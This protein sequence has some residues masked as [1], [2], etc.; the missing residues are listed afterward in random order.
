MAMGDFQTIT[1]IYPRYKWYEAN[2][3][4]EPLGI[5]TLVAMLKQN[6][7]DVRFHDLTFR[8]DLSCLD[9]DVS[10]S[11]LVGMTVS[12]ALFGKAKIVMDHI[13]KVNPNATFIA[14]GPHAT[15]W[16]HEVLD[17]GF[18]YAFQGEA[19]LSFQAFLEAADEQERK[20]TKGLAH[21][22]NGKIVINERMPYIQDLDALPFPDRTVIEYDKYIDGADGWRFEIGML[23]TR[24]CD[25]KCIYCAPTLPTLFGTAR[26]RSPKHV[27]DELG[28]A[29]EV[30]GRKRRVY[31]KDDTFTEP[32]IEWV[33]KFHDLLRER[34]IK[35]RWHCNTRADAVTFE[36]LKL[37]RDVGCECI[38]FG[39]ESGSPKI[40]EFYRKEVDISVVEQAF[41]WCH[42]VGIEATSNI[43]LG[44]PMETLEDLEMTYQLVRRIK[45]DDLT[46][47][48]CTAM[49]GKD[50][51]DWAVE[52]DV[53][54][55]KIS[56]E[57]FDTALNRE[58]GNV[59]MHLKHLT[60][61]QINQYK[62]KLEAYRSRRKLT[63]P[64][65]VA[66]WL[67]ELVG[68][69]GEAL[70]KARFVLQKL[71]IIETHHH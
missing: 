38:S 53:L 49:P 35:L 5:L 57:E 54:K 55:G 22:E 67:R 69:P 61:D 29:L 25:G 46:V 48:Y 20:T 47:Y 19:E 43:M 62:R 31:F 23:K 68:S 1:L 66:K 21:K 71:P 3:L 13:T 59:N 18:Q 52:N 4:G 17:S 30:V 9:K 50:I 26:S 40:L 64:R 63:S 39:V 58:V 32:G 34:R 24:G 36:M 37:M 28:Y 14:G 12:S 60:I 27:V 8:D 10:E 70:T 11:D 44:A 33:S 51:Y 41:S 45:P 65:N 56:Y 6:N 15:F 2:G 7:Y 16:P 42:R